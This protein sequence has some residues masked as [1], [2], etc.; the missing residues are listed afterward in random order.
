MRLPDRLAVLR[1]RNFRQLFIGELV[2]NLGDGLMPV[3]LTFAVLDLTHSATDVGIVLAASSIPLTV[4]TLVSGVWADRLRREWVMVVSDLVRFGVLV[5]GAI[6]FATGLA[7]VWNIALGGFIYGCGDA[8]FF[9]AYSA[10]IQQIVP[11]D[12]LQEAN[13]LRGMSDSLGWFVGP[14]I[15]G[16]LYAVIHA[17]GTFL[18][19]AATFLVSAGF[20][21]SLRVPALVRTREAQSFTAEL[22][23]G[24]REVASRRWLWTM[25]LRTMLVLF[26]TIAPL[27]V[28]AP[29]W[30]KTYHHS[31]ALWGWLAG[32]FSL[33]MLA[34]G[35]IALYYRPR[36]PM[37]VV[38]LMGVTA[39]APM[40]ALA[41]GWSWPTLTAVWF[42]RGI[43]IGLLVA[44]W[45]TTLQL[46]IA[47]EAMAR[48]SS[49]DW[50]TSNGLW[51]LGLVLAGPIAAALGLQATLWLSGVLGLVCG[52]WVL[53]VKDVWRL[54]GQPREA[55]RVA[56]ESA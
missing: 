38:T 36:R 40:F 23:D 15:S 42:L 10:L 35:A 44:V 28:L 45:D 51:P 48:V 43:A 41:L 52:L 14:A 4:L 22:H 13:S 34:G 25:L 24:W 16:M 7:R 30:I 20:L 9:P 39:S 21:L 2:S 56:D 32:L 46:Q 1:L 55:G 8:F 5:V 49:W 11:Q 33:G 50:M 37:V 27:Q 17:S 31:A 53:L 47:P 19:D 18:V 54:H 6:F 26:V 12:R 3:A 29:L